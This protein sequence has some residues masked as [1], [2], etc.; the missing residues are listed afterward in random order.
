MKNKKKLLIAVAA[1]GLLAVGT[2]GVGT[3]AWY[4]VTASA[5]LNAV[6]T[7]TSVGTKSSSVADAEYYV[8]VTYSGSALADVSLSDPNG[9]SWATVGG[10]LRPATG[11][12]PYSTTSSTVGDYVVTIHATENGA[13]LTGGDL[14]TAKANLQA[15]GTD[16]YVT[17]TGSTYVRL[18]LTNPTSGSGTAAEKFAAAFGGAGTGSTKMG[19][20]VNIGELSFDSGEPVLSNFVAAYYSVSG[21]TGNTVPS[22]GTAEA[23]WIPASQTITF[24]LIE[25]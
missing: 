9:N 19:Q 23:E 12:T 8:K 21:N 11:A 2:A 6:A 20:T 14:A 13:A 5:T 1:M 18:T 4:Q 22:D 10:Y 16:Y 24:S 25:K 7:S 17:A 3:A 15:A